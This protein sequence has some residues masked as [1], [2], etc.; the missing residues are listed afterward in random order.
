[1]GD[2]EIDSSSS[3][4]YSGASIQL[5]PNRFQEDLSRLSRL[6]VAIHNIERGW[7]VQDQ[8]SD[9]VISAVGYVNIAVGI[10]LHAVCTKHRTYCGTAV[11]YRSTIDSGN[12]PYRA[13]RKDI[14]P[15][16]GVRGDEEIPGRIHSHALCIRVRRGN[17]FG[18]I[19]RNAEL[20][21]AYYRADHA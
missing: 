2:R 18:A 14:D 5:H 9:S 4:A 10:D 12:P 11:L 8:F 3:H 21:V 13:A 7:R 1:G 15:E 6:I 16:V 20:P 17:G 19:D